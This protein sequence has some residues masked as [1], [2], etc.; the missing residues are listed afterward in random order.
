VN[1][2][3][4]GALLFLHIEVGEFGYSMCKIRISAETFDEKHMVEAVADVRCLSIECDVD[5]AGAVEIERMGWTIERVDIFIISAA[6]DY[7]MGA[8]AHDLV[9]A[10]DTRALSRA[11]LEVIPNS[12]RVSGVRLKPL[13][14]EHVLTHGRRTKQLNRSP[15]AIAS[16][17]TASGASLLA[18][19]WSQSA[20]R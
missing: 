10:T 1:T 4:A 14:N 16:V 8:L 5:L 18:S 11:F 3:S 15:Y 19:Q 7:T 20:P 9:A 2:K 6:T 17:A 13:N 12:E